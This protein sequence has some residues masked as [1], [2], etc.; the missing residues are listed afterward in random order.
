[1]LNVWLTVAVIPQWSSG[2]PSSPWWTGRMNWMNSTRMWH[3]HTHTHTRAHTSTDARTHTRK[4]AQCFG[5]NWLLG[6]TGTHW[7]ERRLLTAV[8]RVGMALW[9]RRIWDFSTW[10]LFSNH[11]RSK[12]LMPTTISLNCSNFAAAISRSCNPW[13]NSL[14]CSPL[15]QQCPSVC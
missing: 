2:R 12:V 11:L 14:R 7:V 6:S 1:M 9:W 10:T 5:S 13:K 15:G 3:T 8:L 4:H